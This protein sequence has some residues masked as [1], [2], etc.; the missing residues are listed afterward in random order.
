MG[1]ALR[2]GMAESTMILRWLC[3]GVV[4]AAAL[5]AS[6]DGTDMNA[7]FGPTMFGLGMT[8]LAATVIEICSEGS[9]P[10]GR[11]PV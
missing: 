2:T 4:L 5:Q 7:W 10:L 3:L 1:A 9:T 8:L 11:R 6:M